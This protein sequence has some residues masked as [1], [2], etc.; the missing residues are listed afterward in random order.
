MAT[1]SSVLAWRIPG[2]GEPG[3]LP[4]MALH[5]VGHD[6]SNLAEA[7]AVV[8]ITYSSFPF[9]WRPMYTIFALFPPFLFCCYCTVCFREHRNNIFLY[10][11]TMT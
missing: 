5:R 7:A 3:G 2:M 6:Q 11:Q 4:S 10:E 8:K 1:P 9:D